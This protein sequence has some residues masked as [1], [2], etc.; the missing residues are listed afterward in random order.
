MEGTQFRKGQEVIFNG[1][2]GINIILTLKP[3]TA[4]V[5]DTNIKIA[6]IKLLTKLRPY[7]KT[8]TI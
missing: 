6:R 4:I 3:K 5:W 8:K 2:M 1:A 7:K